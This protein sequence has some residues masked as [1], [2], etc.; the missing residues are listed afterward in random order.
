MFAAR[1]NG[2]TR[3]VSGHN[4][5]RPV[6]NLPVYETVSQS[7]HMMSNE[8]G[9]IQRVYLAVKER[10]LFIGFVFLKGMHIVLTKKMWEKV[11][12]IFGGTNCTTPKE[13]PDLCK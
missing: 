6:P 9:W 8:K 7:S 10:P 13:E 4:L 3:T 2:A 12:E 11:T 1:H 5:F